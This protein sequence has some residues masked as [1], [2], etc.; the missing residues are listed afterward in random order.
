M[1]NRDV[2]INEDTLY[3]IASAIREK[4][5]TSNTYKPSQM[6]AAIR[7]IETGVPVS[8]ATPAVTIN[9]AT[10]VVT[11]TTNQLAGLVP[12]GITSGTLSLAF[13]PAITVIPSTTSQVAVSA[14]RWLGGDITVEAIPSDYI[15]PTGTYSISSNGIYDVTNFASAEVS[16]YSDPY[17]N[18]YKSLAFR[19]VI[20]AS[21]PYVS[22]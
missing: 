13:Q 4:N 1:A 10:G 3:G 5:S 7:A 19:D 2:L 8:I 9:S 6:S 11:A 21:D 22:E 14:G 12:S 16:I 20:K 15:V 17:Y 18:V